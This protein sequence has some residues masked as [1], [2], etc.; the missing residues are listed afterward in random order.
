VK[1]SYCQGND[2][3]VCFVHQHAE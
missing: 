1:T 2:D 3:N